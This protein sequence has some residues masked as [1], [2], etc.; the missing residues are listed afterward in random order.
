MDTSVDLPAV[1]RNP[2]P[3]ARHPS[4]A[5][6]S[7]GAADR[8]RDRRWYNRTAMADNP[9]F[10]LLLA[11]AACGDGSSSDTSE[12]S[13]A[14]DSTG[15]SSGDSSS[16]T[17]VGT[18]GGGP[19]I[20][21]LCGYGCVPTSCPTDDC[22]GYVCD[23]DNGSCAAPEEVVCD[24]SRAACEGLACGQACVDPFCNDAEDGGMCPESLCDADGVCTTPA[25]FE[26]NP[27]PTAT[28]GGSSGS[29]SGTG[30]G[31]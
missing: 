9:S 1:D 25:G 7:L 19:C 24:A 6:R 10:I 23:A 29:E 14:A 15:S 22:S 18:T 2:G 17:M 30:T 3:R 4:L 5:R 11:I 8:S 20:G 31:R 16:T 13:S 27:C 26:M 21:L 28:E 12:T